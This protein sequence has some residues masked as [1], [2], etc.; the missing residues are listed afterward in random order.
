MN[1]LKKELKNQIPKVQADIKKILDENP[2]EKEKSTE[3]FFVPFVCQLLL[4]NLA[5]KSKI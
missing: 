4:R 5:Q 2:V 3:G 1:L